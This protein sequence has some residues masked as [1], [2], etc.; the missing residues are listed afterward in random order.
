[1]SRRRWPKACESLAADGH[2]YAYARLYLVGWRC[3]RHT[4]AAEAGRPEAPPGPAVDPHPDA[5]RVPGRPQPLP[6][7]APEIGVRMPTPADLAHHPRRPLTARP[8]GTTTPRRTP[9]PATA[10]FRQRWE[11]ALLHSTL[12]P[13]ARLVAL[14]VATRAD[15]GTGQIPPAAMPGIPTVARA[16]GLTE[17]GVRRQLHTLTAAGFLE[18]TV[19]D[20]QGPVVQIV[21]RLPREPS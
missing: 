3:P 14:V 15:Y 13:N 8:A 16:T 2:A 20:Q 1:M 12:P 4:P 21:L 10:P 11:W 5:G 7:A 19:P 6:L 9:P 17:I 18:R